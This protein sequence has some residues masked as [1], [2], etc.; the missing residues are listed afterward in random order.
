MVSGRGTLRG[1]QGSRRCLGAVS[2]F[3]LRLIRESAGLTQ[4]QLAE[5]LGVD[6]ASVQGWESGR[7]P[8]AALRAADLVG[9]RSR[10][11]RCGAQP[12]LLATLEDAIQADLI[13]AETVQAGSQLI[14]ADRHPLGATVHQCKLTNLIT[15]PFTGIVPVPLRD[16]VTVRTRRGPVPDRPTLTEDERTRFFDHLLVTADAHL[17]EYALSRRQA[18][19]LLGFDTRASTAEWLRTEQLRA[20][21]DAG[22]TDHV[23]SWVIVRSSAVALAYGGDRDPLRV[24][25]QQALATDQMERANLNYWAYWVGEIDGIQVDDEFM[26]R[27]DPREWSGVRLLG[28]LLELLRLDSGHVEL[29]IHTVWALLLAHPALLSDHPTLRSAAAGTVEKLAEDSDLS[30]QARRELSDIAYAVRLVYR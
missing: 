4:V 28:H 24:F 17:P 26:V 12:T 5:Q 23:P 11:L 8:L 18:I 30:A 1:G 10:L 27:I 7:R 3:L 13:I 29:D 14:E 15:W 6:V 25:L 9:L 22:H 19:Y 2:G 16:L 21:R 20:L